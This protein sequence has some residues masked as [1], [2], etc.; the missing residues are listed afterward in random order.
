MLCL[1]LRMR[2]LRT[3]NIADLSKPL[4]KSELAKSTSNSNYNIYTHAVYVYGLADLWTTT[5]DNWHI[6]LFIR[7]LSNP[8]LSTFILPLGS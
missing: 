5:L 1:S 3:F 7:R 6:K 8:V 2:F 4:H